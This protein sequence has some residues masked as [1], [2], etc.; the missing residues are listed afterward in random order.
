MSLPQINTQV[1]LP[2]GF[3]RGA[4]IGSIGG[5]IA[6]AGKRNGVRYKTATKRAIR[7]RMASLMIRQVE[8]FN[9]LT[10]HELHGMFRACNHS[11]ALDGIA[12][13]LNGQGFPGTPLDP[14]QPTANDE[15]YYLDDDH[16]WDREW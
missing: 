16:R 12:Q 5:V 10:D 4:T 1:E 2:P 3:H 6:A 13:W 7:M 15:E 8:S 11:L 14:V 9:D